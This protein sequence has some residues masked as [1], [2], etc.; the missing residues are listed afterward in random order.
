MPQNT[1]MTQKWVL[2][3][4]WE[5]GDIISL[6]RKVDKIS[7]RMDPNGNL[8]SRL[9]SRTHI[10]TYIYII[11]TVHMYTCVF[12]TKQI[13]YVYVNPN[14]KII[15]YGHSP[16]LFELYNGWFKLGLYLAMSSRK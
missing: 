6:T 13:L 9:G 1:P 5:M 14:R 3:N 4:I 10:F 8:V 15:T 11:Y 12:A 7:N 2:W 16:H